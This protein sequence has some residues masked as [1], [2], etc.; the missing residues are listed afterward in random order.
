MSKE[1]LT[2]KE[3]ARHFRRPA[4]P[5]RRRVG[6][7]MNSSL[8][9]KPVTV[10]VALIAGIGGF[11][12]VALPDPPK[13]PVVH[14]DADHDA[15][16]WVE[17]LGANYTGGTPGVWRTRTGRLIGYAAYEDAIV[18]KT[19]SCTRTQPAYEDTP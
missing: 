6:G 1:W 5:R 8:S 13:C 4:T 2:Y 3:L 15:D 12:A 19:T 7:R 9:L 11:L 10:C 16:L 17:D 14:A 18:Y